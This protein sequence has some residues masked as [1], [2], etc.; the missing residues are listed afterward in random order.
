M[1]NVEGSITAAGATALE[2]LERSPGVVVNRQN[3]SIALAGK[4]GVIVMM[5]GKMNRMPIDAVV[6]LLAGMPS[7]NIEKIELITTPPANFDAEGNAGFINIVLKQSSDQGL[8]GSYTLSGGLGNGDIASAGINFNYRKNRFNLYGDYSF[9][10]RAQEQ[11]F[12][13]NREVQLNEQTIETDT[14]SVRDPVQRNHNVRLGMDFN[15]SK[16]NRSGLSYFWL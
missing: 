6:Q 16:K 13:F 11:I 14:R 4:D 7:S 10:R 9:S 8:N 2:V 3:N 12:S 1:V 15:L 5:N